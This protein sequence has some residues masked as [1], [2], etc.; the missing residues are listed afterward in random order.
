MFLK[1]RRKKNKTLWL[2]HPAIKIQISS[3]RIIKPSASRPSPDH[4]FFV[5][6]SFIVVTKKRDQNKISAK[7]LKWGG[8]IPYE[9]GI[10]FGWK[11]VLEF[12]SAPGFQLISF[13]SHTHIKEGKWIF[14]CEKKRITKNKYFPLKR[15]KKGKSTMATV[16]HRTTL[17]LFVH[18]ISMSTVQVDHVKQP[19]VS[20]QIKEMEE[21]KKKKKNNRHKEEREN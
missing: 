7:F 5:F 15:G 3:Q 8:V 4:L 20:S 21:G 6:L 16:H 17:F 1:R 9:K 14:L 2:Q 12:S 19:L 10:E 18:S 11:Q 13:A